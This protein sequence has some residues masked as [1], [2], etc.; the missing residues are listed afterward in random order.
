MAVSIRAWQTHTAL[1]SPAGGHDILGHGRGLCKRGGA[2]GDFHETWVD[3][4]CGAHRNAGEGAEDLAELWRREYLS[5]RREILLA[6]GK[7]RKAEKYWDGRLERP[8]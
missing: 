8:G 6:Q 3:G 1:A 7:S 2:C 4:Q 5:G